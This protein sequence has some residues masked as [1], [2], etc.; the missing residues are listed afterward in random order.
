MLIV[1]SGCISLSVAQ[2]PIV[3]VQSGEAAVLLCPNMSIYDSLTFW[4]RLVNKAR[5]SC[6]SV[7]Y[8]TSSDV[9][10][11]DGFGNGT[12][13]MSSNKSTVFLNINPVDLSDAG[14]YF[15]GFY[16]SARPFFSVIQLNVKGKFY[17]WLPC[18]EF[19][20]QVVHWNSEHVFSSHCGYYRLR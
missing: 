20:W 13:E 19:L 3:E 7:M 14:L 12:V 9:L 16:F 1:V 15:C 11:C 8:K 6:I 10:Y 17:I 18:F 4:F 5:I 2:L